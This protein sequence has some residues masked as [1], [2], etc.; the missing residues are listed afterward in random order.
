MAS[1]ALLGV[2]KIF[3]GLSRHRPVGGLVAL[4]I[5]TIVAALAIAL[6]R[7]RTTTAGREMVARLSAEFGEKRSLARGTP[8]AVA[9]NDWA[10][11]VG[12]YGASIIA[13]GPLS[14]LYQTLPRA[15]DG[16]GGSGCS[17]G[18]GGGG[19]GCGGGGC[20][21]CGGG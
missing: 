18:C 15:S 1:P 10:M 8:E 3:V 7:S 11:M 20:G 21:G 16:S 14:P 9:G 19:G 12:L 4:V 5:M 13:V 17:A 6:W 2:C